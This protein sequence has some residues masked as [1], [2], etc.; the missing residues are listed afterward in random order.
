VGNRVQQRRNEEFGI[1]WYQVWL[2]PFVHIA[3]L[4]FGFYQLMDSETRGEV[5]LFFVFW[6]VSALLAFVH[7]ARQLRARRLRLRVT[8]EGIERLRPSPSFNVRWGEIAR[9]EVTAESLTLAVAGG[10][11][12]VPRTLPRYTELYGVISKCV[13]SSV[14]GATAGLPAVLHYRS[15]SIG[16][17]VSGAVG[18]AG[19]LFILSVFYQ[20]GPVWFALVL[21]G[22]LFGAL[23]HLYRRSTR[24][25]FYADRIVVRSWLK[26][27]EYLGSDLKDGYLDEFDG[28]S[29]EVVLRLAFTNGDSL[30]LHDGNIRVEQL[31]AVLKAHYSLI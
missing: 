2:P 21:A 8:D 20:S 28:E 4:G 23:Q 15:I 5:Y 29:D 13:P 22:S 25:E 18:L 14:L 6:V 7:S 30:E 27:K 16:A 9:A 19:W 31:Y 10:E 3:S 24:Y 17:S 26:S 1:P 11:I 12:I